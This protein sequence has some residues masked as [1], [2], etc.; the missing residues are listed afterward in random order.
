MFKYLKKMIFK[1]KLHDFYPLAATRHKNSI[2][3]TYSIRKFLWGDWAIKKIGGWEGLGGK[4]VVRGVLSLKVKVG[5]LKFL[6]K[7]NRLSFQPRFHNCPCNPHSWPIFLRDYISKIYS[8]R[9]HWIK[10]CKNTSNAFPSLTI[11]RWRLS[12]SSFPFNLNCYVFFCRRIN[13]NYF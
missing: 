11:A 13:F 9:Q 3:I 6:E 5:F 10:F 4:K 12:F 7:H 1:S 2:Q 8:G